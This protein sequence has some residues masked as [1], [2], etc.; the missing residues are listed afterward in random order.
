M[1]ELR[2]LG[3]LELRGADGHE[4]RR[5]LQ[6]PKRLA[7]LAYLAVSTPRRFH[8]RDTLLGIFWPELDSDHARAALRRSLYFLRRSLG[9]NVIVGRGDE[10]IGL[11]SGALWCDTTAFEEALGAGEIAS[12]LE[13]YRGDL[14]Q[15]FYI[16]GAPEF[17]RWLERERARLLERAVGSGWALAEQLGSTKS[18][19]AARWARWVAAL[20]P[21]DEAA[22]RRLIELLAH[23]GDRAGA[24]RAYDEFARRLRADYEV[25]PSRETQTLVGRL[26]T[27]VDTTPLAQVPNGLAAHVV[28]VL[29]FTVRGGRELAYLGEGMVDLL[30]TTLDGAGDLR[31]VDPRALLAHLARED[32]QGLDPQRGREIARHFGAGLYLLGSIVHAG[33]HIRISATLY[34]AHARPGSSADVR[35]TSEAGIFDMVDE[36]AR[37][38]LGGQSSGPGARLA[39][40]AARTTQSLSALKAYLRGES[41]FRAGRYFQALESFQNAAAEDTSFALAYYRLAAAAAATANLELARDASEQA[42]RSRERLGTH[43]RLLVDAQRAWLR[44]AA[45]EAER[46]YTTALAT[47]VDDIEAWFLLGDVLFH[48]NPLRGRPM[49]EAREPFERALRYEPDHLSSLVHLARLAAFEGRAAEL[50]SLVNRVL[51]LSPA[52]DRALSMRALRAFALR[53]EIEKARIVAALMRAR[54]LAVG[55]AFTDIVLYAHDL[56][57]SHRLARLV[58]KLTRAPEGK[59]LCLIVLAHL[60]LTRGRYGKA[61]ADLTRAIAQDAAWGLEIRALFALLP[62]RDAFAAELELV[63]DAVV[64]WNAGAAQPN[65]NQVLAAHNGVHDVLRL[66]L[67]GAIDARLGRARDALAAAEELEQRR[68]SDAR[69]AFAAQLARSVR[70]QVAYWAGKPAD[71]LRIL[72]AAQPET[73]YQLAIT[74]PFYSGAYERYLRA[75]LLREL[76]RH[77]E[78]LAWY[79]ALGE[80]SPYELIYLAPAHLRQAQIHEQHGRHDRA[81]FHAARA[82]ELWDSCDAELRQSV[83]IATQPSVRV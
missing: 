70:A 7:L 55:I 21:H 57:G 65:A 25:E 45:D 34:D 54:A 27:A 19:D 3:A 1:I 75:E 71:A 43:D 80:S 53:N 30:S 22:H 61:T 69:D 9:E 17:E 81:A 73:W 31:A 62:F 67:L 32:G 5:V 15:G 23:L 14:L 16:S 38:L 29:P 49:A 26:R 72:S 20:A 79:S 18:S 36:L 24:L 64:R 50:D 41:D 77:E 52:G 59:A 33:G 58:T 63:R 83:G 4:F 82:A 78:A 10:E 11:A 2:T 28:A 66:Y 47:H 51:Q 12:A 76:G 48:H 39:K 40:L 68:A 37:Q 74:S 60:N 6:Q 35:G 56:S 8:R 44:G 46:L 13:L 42:L